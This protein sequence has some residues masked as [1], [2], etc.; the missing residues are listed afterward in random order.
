MILT[1]PGG[2]T[3]AIFFSHGIP[4]GTDTSE[5]DFGVFTAIREMDL[6]LVRVGTE[7]YEIPDA[8]INGG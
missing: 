1:R 2:Q 5:A 8:L 6:H 3:R 7:R 4:I